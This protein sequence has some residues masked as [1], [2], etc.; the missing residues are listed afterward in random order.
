MTKKKKVIL[1]LVAA[2][3]VLV[4]GGTLALLSAGTGT[5]SNTFSSSKYLNI[6]LREP[7]WDG[8]T[9]DETLPDGSE[10]DGEHAK[11]TDT[12]L[13][14][15]QSGN[16]LP[17]Q[18]IPKD[19]TVKNTGSGS[20]GV[21]AYVALKVTYSIGGNAVS[22]AAFQ[23]ELLQEA[24]L[25]FDTAGWALIQDAGTAGQI[26]LYGTGDSSGSTGTVLEVGSETSPLFKNVP[27]NKD[28]Q[29]VATTVG[30][31]SDAHT[32]MLP[33]AFKITVKAVAV[34]SAHVDAGDAANQLITLIS[35]P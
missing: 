3:A 29:L 5:K 34:Q 10:P 26:Y 23:S 8:Y 19:P 35:Q 22:Y 18:T 31:G 6:Q 12:A 15:N 32:E 13:G 14:I 7:A 1:C 21:P 17:G 30:E 4:I 9:W 20:E 24:G 27:I 16:Y 11:T 25:D 33:P 2:A 28:L